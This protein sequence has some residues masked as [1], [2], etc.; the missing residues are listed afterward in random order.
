MAASSVVLP[1]RTSDV[2][3][4]LKVARLDFVSAKFPEAVSTR[5]A[6]YIHIKPKIPQEEDS[7]EEQLLKNDGSDGD[8]AT[9]SDE[10]SKKHTE[11]EQSD[12][13]MSEFEDAI[14]FSGPVQKN[15]KKNVI[16]KKAE[17]IKSESSSEEDE[18]EEDEESSQDD[19]DENTEDESED[20]SEDKPPIENTNPSEST[21]IP[22]K[23]A[24]LKKENFEYM[25]QKEKI[26]SRIQKEDDYFRMVNKKYTFTEPNTDPKDRGSRAETSRVMK[27]FPKNM[28]APRG[29]INNGVTCYMNSAVQA[30]IH[31][32]AMA[33]YLTAVNKGEYKDTISPRSVTRDL[34]HLFARMTDGSNGRKSISPKQLIRRLDEI[35]P[36]MSEWNQEDAHEYFMSLIGRLQEDSVPKGQ[37]LKS[38]ILHE[39][40]GGTFLQTV[41]CQEC[42]NKSETHQDFFDIQVS[43]DKHELKVMGKSTLRGSLR[44]YFDQSFIKKSKSEGYDCE[45]CKKKTSA[46]TIQRIEEAPEY[47]ILSIKR[48]EY[49]S[50]RNSSQKIK[51]HLAIA[52]TIELTQYAVNEEPMRY[53]LVAFTV[54]EGRSASSGHYVAYCMQP[55]NTWALYDDDYVHQLSANQVYRSKDDVY[56]LV[57][58]RVRATLKEGETR[59]ATPPV[60]M[61]GLADEDN[62]NEEGDEDDDEEDDDAEE[63]ETGK[64]SK[65]Q[66]SSKKA[67]KMKKNTDPSGLSRKLSNSSPK[68]HRFPLARKN[69][70]D[71]ISSTSS[72]RSSGKIKKYGKRHLRKG[73]FGSAVQSLTPVNNLKKSRSAPA[74]MNEL[75][76][77]KDGEGS[78]SKYFS[79]NNNHHHQSGKNAFSKLAEKFRL[80]GAGKKRNVAATVNSKEEL[81][82]PGSSNSDS[83]QKKRKLDKDIDDIFNRL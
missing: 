25:T 72:V 55:D 78:T 13:D 57:Y 65:V 19:D 50:N 48:Y 37:K 47:L 53:Q 56:F 11:S 39:M 24:V 67:K 6:S 7:E 63:G 40:F 16:S 64:I 10:S 74:G 34:A 26:L 21:A 75:G 82:R 73:S 28:S 51:Q 70:G 54:H 41:V 33:R 30:L 83:S 69:S 32:P 44:Q 80:N 27:T 38:S 1:K 12:V 14:D 60:F 8:S 2:M 36:L 58:T 81:N 46:S 3:E 43:I 29:L 68:G 45:K 5:P 35:N 15:K 23:E 76:S 18:N 31:V 62:E 66:I 22:G 9:A 4:Q 59:E 52:P 61:N 17:N 42:K 77:Q 49:T 79:K 71:S 20:E